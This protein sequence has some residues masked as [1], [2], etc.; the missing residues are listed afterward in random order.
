MA[1]QNVQAREAPEGWPQ[2]TGKQDE[3]DDF[4]ISEEVWH[5]EDP[6]SSQST[7]T[8]K[9]TKSDDLKVRIHLW[10]RRIMAGFQH[11]RSKLRT[12]AQVATISTVVAAATVF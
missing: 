1:A 5:S 4:W 6:T 10:D 3:E 7:V 2:D 8:K 12:A 11:L 9:A